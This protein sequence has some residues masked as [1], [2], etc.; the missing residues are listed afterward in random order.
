MSRLIPTWILLTATL[1]SGW[2]ALYAAEG[3]P[4]PKEVKELVDKAFAYLKQRQGEDGS[5]VPKIAGPGV[6]ALV[7]ASLLRHGYGP[8]DPLVAKTLAFLEK[9]VQKDGGVYDKQLANYTTSVALMAF[10]EANGDGKYNALIKNATQFLK[11]LQFTNEQVEES[12]AKFGGVGYDAGKRPDLSNTQL[13]LDALLAAGVPKDDPAVQRCLKFISRCQN[14]PGETNDQ[15]FAK[16]TTAADKGGLTYTPLDPDDSPHKTAEGGLRSLG[17]MTYAGLKSF[18]YAGVSKDDPRVKAAVAWIR[19]HYTLH[20]NPGMGQAGLYY[21]Y[22]TFG[23][24][25]AALGEN[26]FADAKGGKHNWRR[27]LFEALKK[28]Q[29]EDG[30]WIN[31]GDKQFG[32]AAPELATAFAVLTLRYCQ[33]E[34]KK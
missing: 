24:G 1:L 11:K 27:E 20:E 25:L 16:K 33:P 8:D 21:Y 31:Q 6:S 29:R 15:P 12:D 4:D 2:P 3:D 14:L 7:A 10:A 9:K 13:F 22:H 18:L 34:K 5:F 28:R 26:P 17:G 30:S 23:K 32:E 19:N